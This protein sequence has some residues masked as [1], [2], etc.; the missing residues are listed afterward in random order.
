ME[1]VLSRPRSDAELTARSSTVDCDAVHDAL[2]IPVFF[3]TS[4]SL[5]PMKARLTGCSG[6]WRPCGR[7]GQGR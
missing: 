7:S 6:R 1:G 2:D 5:R 4:M 3:N